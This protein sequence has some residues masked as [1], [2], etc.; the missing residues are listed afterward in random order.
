VRKPNQPV[1][2]RWQDD[3][4]HVENQIE[5]Q[6]EV[7]ADELNENKL[8][9]G[10]KMREAAEAVEGFVLARAYRHELVTTAQHFSQLQQQQIQVF[11]Q[12]VATNKELTDRALAQARL[13]TA[14]PPQPES[15]L[16]S[17]PSLLAFGNTL[18]R[19]FFGRD[20]SGDDEAPVT[21]TIEND[22]TSALQKE[23][24]RLEAKLAAKRKGKPSASRA[25]K[26]Q[27]ISDSRKQDQADPKPAKT[28][29]REKKPESPATSP[30]SAKAAPKPAQIPP[31]RSVKKPKADAAKVK[32]SLGSGSK[33]RGE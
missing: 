10:K 24:K 30:K 26:S 21:A 9:L 33:E 17:L 25:R 16:N 29:A 4:R 13:Q 5:Y 14:P 3:P 12:M 23:K 6:A 7:F 31:K 8:L 22:A 20:L 32:G 15:L 11:N 28:T 1:R 18:A 27:K 19:G 2:E